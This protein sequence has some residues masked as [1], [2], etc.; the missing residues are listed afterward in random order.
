MTETIEKPKIPCILLTGFLGAGKTTLLSTLLAHPVF[1]GMKKAALV[2]EFSKLGI[3]A[4]VLPKGDWPVVEV[5]SGSIFCACVRSDLIA[6]LDRIARGT[7]AELLFIEA[8]G[9]AEPTDFTALFQT[10]YLRSRYSPAAT[11]AVADAVNFH[12]LEGILPVVRKQ[13]AMADIILLNKV[14]LAPLQTVEEAGRRLQE[15]NTRAKLFRT[16]RCAFNLPDREYLLDGQ[17]DEYQHGDPHTKDHSPGLKL[18]GKPP[19]GAVSCE[20]RS[21][22]SPSTEAFYEF[23][24]KNSDFILR[25]KGTV[26]LGGGRHFVEVVNGVVSSRPAGQIVLGIYLRT[27]MSFILRGKDVAVF[28]DEFNSILV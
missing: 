12:K 1:A 18:R 16:I 20:I 11:I 9:L 28:K 19:S 3:D 26:H 4:A 17:W 5:D 15:L 21:T 24:Q 27:A 2:N 7:D 25:A 14:D 22:K 13:L 23:L 6:G 8:T 10:D